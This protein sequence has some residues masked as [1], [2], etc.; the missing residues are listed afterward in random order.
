MDTLFN[1]ELILQVFEIALALGLITGFG[2]IVRNIYIYITSS[3]LD[4]VLV[5]KYNVYDV[6]QRV[7]ADI[8]CSRML[9]I[10]V[11][12]GGSVPKVTS[13]LK[14]TIIQEVYRAPLSSI[15]MDWQD[16]E[17]DMAYIKM[18]IS[19]DQSADGTISISRDNMEDGMLK[20]TY[21]AHGIK[22]SMLSYVTR[23][24]KA[25]YFISCNYT[26]DLHLSPFRQARLEDL[27]SKLKAL[28]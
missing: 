14:S 15:K 18:L 6:M 26:E 7:M 28:I 27:S 20:H 11:H 19:L 3:T 23:D 4:K 21:Q 25:M 1:W 22:S 12:N 8:D 17:V 9:L 2:A 13:T 16:R 5:R 24:S 10:K